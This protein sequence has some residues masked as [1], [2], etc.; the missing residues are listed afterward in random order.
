[1]NIPDFEDV[2]AA[3]MRI[4][5][6]IHRTPVL[7]SSYLSHLSGAR[8]FFKCENLQ[9]VGAFKA[10]GACNAVF[11]LS[12]AD[13][14]R[15][16]ATHSSGNHAAALCYAAAARG[17]DATVVMPRNAP[18]AKKAAVRSYGGRIIECEPTQ[19]AREAA[20]AQVIAENGADVVHPYD[21]P[22]V[23][24]GQATC[25]LEMIEDIDDLD[26]VVAPI[27]GG[28]LISG[29]CLALSTLSPETRI[30]AAEPENADDAYRSFHA[31]EIVL[32]DAQQSVADGLKTNLKPRTW[33]F[34]SRYVTDVLLASETEI[35]DAMY[36]TWE[37]MKI[38]IE[39]SSAVPLAIILKNQEL[40]RD[41]RV[42]VII[43]G[44]NVDI[45][46]CPGCK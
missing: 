31:G 34:V 22:R 38:I 29:T 41:Q 16:V 24:A 15:G 46:H 35:L 36:L 2:R 5:P 42:G 30:Y 45:R 18:A 44:G 21:D 1:M 7:T 8:L 13:A 23:I 27:G 6:H 9:K 10:R 40:F 12:D 32:Q 28:G 3:H 19:A 37:R 26:A 25:A 17:I 14:A 4:L 20:L 11:G 39:P 33:H 43:T